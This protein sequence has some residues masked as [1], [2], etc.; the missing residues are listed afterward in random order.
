MNAGSSSDE[1]GAT[2]WEACARISHPSMGTLTNFEVRTLSM[3]QVNEDGV[4]SQF[5]VTL[6]AKT[7]QRNDSLPTIR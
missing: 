3:K 4:R 1:I 2:G 7:D 6:A 5:L